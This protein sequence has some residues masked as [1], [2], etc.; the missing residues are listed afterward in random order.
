MQQDYQ[1]ED[2]SSEGLRVFTTLD[3]YIQFKTEEAIKTTLPLL[4]KNKKLQAA[5]IVVSPLNGDVLAV[6]GDRNPS[7]KG[8]NRA[9]NA[10]RQIGSLIKPV[11]YLTAI[12]SESG[13]TLASML[14]DS[15]FTYE[16]PDKQ[17][18]QPDWQPQNYDKKYH[19]DVTLY[20][21]LLKSYNIPAARTGLDVG[22]DKVVKT[23][24][25]LGIDKT[26]PEYPSLALGAVTLSPMQVASMYQ[27]LAANGFHSP[28]RSVS[29]V[30]DKNKQP[31]ERYSLNVESQVRHEAVALIN[32]ALIDVT[33][34]GTAKRLSDNLSIQ[35]AGKTGTSETESQP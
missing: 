35:L 14:D 32:S 8:F 1:S 22:L 26:I 11:I 28:L 19:G 7:F 20:E 18:N 30:L 15:E 2:L 21:S 4:S 9:I 34:Y 16:N 23:I 17:S 24:S 27:S 29:S 6:V 31:L 12:E 3:P 33:K 5:A 10:E 13:Y 25:A